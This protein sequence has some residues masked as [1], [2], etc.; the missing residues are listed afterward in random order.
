MN[1]YIGQSLPRVEDEKFLR[2]EA[3]YTDDFT[4][5]N[6]AVAVMV[7]SPHAHA[8]LVSCDTSEAL[9]MPGV[10]GVF[11]SADLKAAG[12]REIPCFTR[13]PPY[14]L[15]NTDGS[16]MA[17]ASQYPLATDRVRY[18]GEPIAVVVAET[19]A[20]AKD[21]A[22]RV[23]VNF[24][25]LPA[26]ATAEAARAEA[27]PAIWPELPDNRSCFWETG[28][29]EATDAEFKQAAKIVEIDVAYPR[30]IIAFMEP[31]SAVCSYEPEAG[32]YVLEAGCQSA[33]WLQDGLARIF[34]VEKDEVRVLV[35]DTGGGF[36]ARAVVYPEFVCALFA[37]RKL[38]RPVKWTAERSES[39]VADGQAR[40]QQIKAEMALD[41]EGNF[42]A[43]RFQVTWIHGG[44]LAPRSAF[45]VLGAMPSMICGPYRMK[46][47]HF[48]FE[49]VFTTTTP[50]VSYR[51]VG[52]TEAGYVLERLVDAA[53]RETGIDPLELRRRNLIPPE[54]MPYASVVGLTYEQVFFERHMDDALQAL[55]AAGFKK[56]REEA[57]ERGNWRGLSVS[58]YIMTS[59]GVPEEFASI[60]LGGDGTAVVHTGTQDFGMGHKTVFAQIVA[61]QLGVEPAKVEIV[62]GDTDIVP[63]G[64]G[65]HGS[66]C[67]RIGGS[68]IVVACD[69]VVAKA[70]DLA[71]EELEVVA[72][73][74]VF[75]AGVFKV[76]GTDLQIT[77]A[78]VAGRAAEAGQPVMVS[79]TYAVDGPGYPA[80]AHGV[81]VEVDPETGD[82]TLIN[83]VT[84]IDPGRLINPML[85]E[86]QM[87]G[88][89]VQGLGEAMVE[90]VVHDDGTAQLLS[91][92]LMDFTLP[93]ADDLPEIKTILDPAPT[94]ANPLGAKGAG[95]M[96]CMVVQAVAV[97]AVL[98]ALSP[99]RISK[100]D[101]PL[102][103]HRVWQAIRAHTGR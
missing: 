19:V 81:E 58:P 103:P 24:R 28:D 36:G 64:E 66:R 59:G 9:K 16:E 65:G 100:L 55:D 84:V 87:H 72:E 13:T 37:A 92:S 77:L 2:G 33:H 15:L 18:A 31:R 47:Q 11:T 21:A 35:P 57:R 98:D 14:Q 32:R 45:V 75:E 73:D 53:A 99:L 8:E 90:R 71:V 42:L 93:R 46:A 49:G 27:A 94:P 91:G 76:K 56:R 1:A 86:G 20:A 39:F 22:E 17:E 80:G 82:V 62:F 43:V 34:N 4:R 97:N 38:G 88:G 69:A 12:I 30:S 70:R 101:M 68:S 54:S 61:D 83:V 67:M 74:L 26:V 102:T 23:E 48:S 44:Y 52:R 78:E 63:R 40:S 5:D 60:Q 29:T 50:L 96:G 79:E 85:V 41:A 89:I 6:Q 51:G 7:R 3:R 25:E 10:L 95:E